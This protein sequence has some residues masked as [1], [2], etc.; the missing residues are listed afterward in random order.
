MDLPFYKIGIAHLTCPLLA[1]KAPEDHLAVLDLVEDSA[2]SELFS[3]AAK[4]GVGIELNFP[5]ENYPEKDL[6]RVMR[7]Y[8]A[9][10]N[11]GCKFY[12]GTDA[13]HPQ[14]FEKARE[15]FPMYVKLLGLTEKDKFKV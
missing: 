13:H 1:P 8:E 12:F 14:R 5:V 2:L 9:A 3:L 10:K 15:R 6:P 7:I 11:A 4:T